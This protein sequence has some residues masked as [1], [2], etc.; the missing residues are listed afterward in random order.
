MRG[1]WRWTDE[2]KLPGVWKLQMLVDRL[3]RGVFAK[4]DTDSVTHDVL[5]VE[6]LTDSYS[7]LLR[8]EGD[9]DATE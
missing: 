7:I 5:P 2:E 3:D 1:T 9:H 6:E 4:I 8:M